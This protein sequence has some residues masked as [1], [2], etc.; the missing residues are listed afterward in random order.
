[1]VPWWGKS[2]ETICS[3]WWT[4][5]KKW[6]K[7]KLR[8]S[9][10]HDYWTIKCLRLSWTIL[11]EV[12]TDRQDYH[13]FF[14]R[15]ISKLFRGSD[16]HSSSCYDTK[17]DEFL[18]HTIAGNE[19]W[20]PYVNMEPKN[21]AMLWGHVNLPWKPVKRLWTKHFLQNSLR[22]L[23]F[24]TEDVYSWLSSWNKALQ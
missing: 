14:A 11:Y 23:S 1:M 7:K 24:R 20:V 18:S 3:Y 9:T 19:T 15:W 21:Q 17:N 8:K 4:C 5:A 22:Q 16:W 6:M 12:A 13:K 10:I 2:W